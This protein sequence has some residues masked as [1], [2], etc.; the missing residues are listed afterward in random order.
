MILVIFVKAVAE[1]GVIPYNHR[2]I[3]NFLLAI[4][5]KNINCLTRNVSYHNTRIS[6]WHVLE[7]DILD[8]DCSKA[9]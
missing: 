7:T 8:S 6:T 1:L 4:K 2:F 3:V 9:S 5:Q